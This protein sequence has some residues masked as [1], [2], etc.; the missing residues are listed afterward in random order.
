MGDDLRNLARAYHL[1]ARSHAR[2]RRKG[3]GRVPY[4]NHVIEVADLVAQAG[5]PA[6][7]VMAAVLHDVVEDSEV[8]S[9]ELAEVFGARVARLVEALTNPPEWEDLPKLE[10]KTRQA[11]HVGAADADVKLIKIADQTSNLHDIAREPEAWK[12][13]RAREYV[14]GACRVVDA[15]RGTDAALE[16]RF[17]AAVDEALAAIGR[18]DRPS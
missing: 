13:A 2:Q 14:E 1:A 7:V 3:A 6:E 17:D 9:A 18:R 5:A 15:C 11:A 12:V 8:G 4:V 16:L 10:M